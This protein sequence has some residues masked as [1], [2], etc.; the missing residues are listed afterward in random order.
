[1]TR[2]KIIPM[3]RVVL[4]AGA[5]VVG[6]P[7]TALADEIWLEPANQDAEKQVGNWAVASV[8]GATHF[9]FHVP[10]NFEVNPAQ[11]G[12]AII[13]LIPPETGT[14][15]YI[16]RINVARATQPF[17]S[18]P[19]DTGLQMLS[20]TAGLITEI[21]ISSIV[22]NLMPS[23]YVT[24]SFE[25][26]RRKKDAAQVVGMRFQYEGAEGTVTSV[27][28]GTGL[29][30]GP[31]TTS[32][33]LSVDVGTTA[34]KIPQI[35][36]TG[37]LPVTIIP[38]GIDAA[39]ISGGTVSNTEFDS[40][41]GVASSVQGQF[42]A[43]GTM[44]TQ[45]NTAVSINGG[46]INGTSIGAVVRDAGAFTTVIASG[47]AEFS[48]N[49]GIGTSAPSSRL[50]VTENGENI[51]Q[52]TFTQA[53]ANA[54]LNIETQ[55]TANAFTPGLFW[56][57]RNDNPTKPKGGIYLRESSAGT[58]MYFG[59]SNSYVV[60]ITNDAMVINEAGNV[61]IGT[62]IP[63]AKLSVNG[64]ANKPGGGSWSTFSDTRLKAI[65]RPFDAGL[66]EVLKLQAVHYRYNTD[67]PLGLPDEGE[68][69]GFSAQ[70]VQ[71]ILPEAVSTG[72]H[73]YLMVNNDPIL[74]AMLN[75]IKEQ[76]KT[77]EELAARLSQENKALRARIRQLEADPSGVR[78]SFR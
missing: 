4:L 59:T 35:D 66:E 9:A 22:P 7:L 8:G 47:A 74:W 43:L 58:R 25:G 45:N 73:G 32:G 24:V 6:W 14:L 20:V 52:T 68:H 39:K 42:N 11:S 53:L 61:G 56:S 31:I 30:G 27:A 13:V 48:G 69:V 36:G 51:I 40:L 12:T 50:T 41:D 49:V 62:D 76:Q 5:V 63:T 57:T 28:T 23:D 70:A 75:A 26:P 46:A 78:V 33:T 3:L 21:D 10:D 2:R 44:S 54:G 64:T 77:I 67:N 19:A 18:L 15:E 29:T 1:M 65:D 17:G 37:L 38:S 60:G 34:G 71:D 55:F 16:A 72:S